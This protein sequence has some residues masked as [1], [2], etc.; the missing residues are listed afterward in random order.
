MV[1]A[2]RRGEWL[3][4]V[5]EL[6]VLALVIGPPDIRGAL[7]AMNTGYLSGHDAVALIGALLWV[8]MAVLAIVIAVRVARG[9]RRLLSRRALPVAAALLVG[10]SCLTVGVVRHQASTF[11]PCCGSLERAQSALADGR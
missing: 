11:T 4:V 10:F 6:V 5:A 1:R 3:L 2:L 9:S 8:G 7:D